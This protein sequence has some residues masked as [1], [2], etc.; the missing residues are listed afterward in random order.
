MNHVYELLSGSIPGGAAL[1]FSA[2]LF[3]NLTLY[4]L[5]KSELLN[6]GYIKKTVI[7]NI[8]IV[9]LYSSIWGYTL[10]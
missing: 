7:M 9:F 6:T 5:K 8:V 4:F 10:P 3:A 2:I 1:L